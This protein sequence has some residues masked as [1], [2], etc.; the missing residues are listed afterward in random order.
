MELKLSL[1][2]DPTRLADVQDLLSGFERRASLRVQVHYQSWDG[3]WSGL[4]R[5]S[6]HGVA[7]TV[8]EIGTSWVPDLVGMN[9]LSPLPA[10]VVKELG[11]QQDYV[12]QSWKSCFLFGN[13][14]M[15]SVPWVSGARVIYYRKDLLA[16]AGLD[17]ET[18]FASPDAMLNS[19]RQLSEAGIARPWITSTVASLN[20]FHLISSWIWAAG[21]DY[22][23]EDGRQLL[24]AEPKAIDGMAAFFALGRSMGPDPQE[25][26]SYERAIDLFW[27]GQ[28]AA[29]L[30][31]TWIYET[32]KPD[33]SPEVLENLGVA[34]APGPAYVGGSNL[35]I[36]TNSENK[37]AAAKLML[38]MSEPE[39]VITMAGVTGL[40]PAR[41][42]LLN[43]PEVVARD[44]GEVMN[45][46]IETGR[47]LP[48]QMFSAMLEDKLRYAFGNIWVDVMKSP[49]GDLREMIAGH[50]LP[51][52]ERL[53]LSIYE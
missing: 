35:V 16:R 6:L 24:F 18:A 5:G 51:L 32:Q 50:L 10:S 14:Q 31:G 28:A 27:K 45:K 2:G 42:S 22:I 17:P 43:S 15:W 21:G 13:P 11:G 12:S 30:D 23:S 53:Q 37:D 7:P 36:W 9:A 44:F 29:T 41:R 3:A 4:V 8:S 34:L 40:A 25:E 49:D 26:Y 1:M 19:V 47:A 20:T 48:N 38:F 33:A 39:S 46:A 52:K